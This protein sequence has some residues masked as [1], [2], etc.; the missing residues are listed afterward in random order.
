MSRGGRGGREGLT[1]AECEGAHARERG[2][3]KGGTGRGGRERGL[4]FLSGASTSFLK[5]PNWVKGGSVSAIT[6][7]YDSGSALCLTRYE[8]F[9]V[10]L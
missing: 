6:L 7:E 4:C 1:E 2:I 10:V 9:G 5:Q 8:Y 3:E